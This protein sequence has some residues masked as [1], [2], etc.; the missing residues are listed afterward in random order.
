MSDRALSFFYYVYSGILRRVSVAIA[1]KMKYTEYV[2]RAKALGY[3]QYN[4]ALEENKI[5]KV[6]RKG[7]IAVKFSTKITEGEFGD[8]QTYYDVLIMSFDDFI[9]MNPELF[10]PFSDK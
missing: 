4:T 9:D 2:N 10:K 6:Y 5:I 8:T 3:K 1:S 7:N